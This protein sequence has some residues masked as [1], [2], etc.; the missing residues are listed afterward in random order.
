MVQS[1]NTLVLRVSNSRRGAN[2]LPA[3]LLR[4]VFLDAI[5]PVD[6]SRYL[7]TRPIS[8]NPV[9]S[10][11][12]AG[13]IGWS[14]KHYRISDVLALTHVCHRWR[15]VTLAFPE[16][17]RCIFN[18]NAMATSVSLSRVHGKPLS[19]FAM[20]NNSAWFTDICAEYGSSIRQLVWISTPQ[21]ATDRVFT[22]STLNF[23]APALERLVMARGKMDLNTA[24][25]PKSVL[26]GDT[27][28]VKFFSAVNLRWF[29]LNRF[30]NLTHFVFT[31]HVRLFELAT[32]LH[33]C[34]KLQTLVIRSQ[35]TWEDDGKPFPV[36]HLPQLRRLALDCSYFPHYTVLHGFLDRLAFDR[37]RAAIQVEFEKLASRDHLVDI[38]S[39]LLGPSSS[40]DRVQT[41]PPPPYTRAYMKAAPP[42]ARPSFT[43]FT[44]SATGGMCLK[45]H[46]SLRYDDTLVI[47][48]CMPLAD[49]TEVW[50]DGLT[51]DLANLF[52]MW[53]RALPALRVVVVV[54]PPRAPPAQLP[55][56]NINSMRIS[57]SVDG[58]EHA[59]TQLRGSI[60]R[61][62]PN[63][64]RTLRL[65]YADE[66]GNMVEV[67]DVSGE[68]GNPLP[69]VDT[70]SK[71]LMPA[72]CEEDPELPAWETWC[73]AK[74]WI[75]II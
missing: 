22:M 16:L 41:A 2:R 7:Y 33:G 1:C 37:S 48:E 49:V 17:W 28:S 40:P 4:L 29:P 19:V 27:S 36:I 50:F 68:T 12:A 57:D 67:F 32:F 51:L 70:P 18:T 52:L 24:Y 65:F 26:R 13:D 59:L 39:T 34:G 58:S 45:C 64:P 6:L 54:R 25:S 38:Q 9:I 61:P 11:T 47:K 15:E 35:T 73:G 63:H 75:Q 69:G 72:C 43:I 74:D 44:T 3:E 60:L 53:P 71:L 56:T 42:H 5:R 8:F 62:R 14:H 46:G 23:R 31:D 55:T 30:P 66:M 20:G 10:R 21:P